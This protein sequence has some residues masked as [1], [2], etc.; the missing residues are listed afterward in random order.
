MQF[1]L[2][3]GLRSKASPGLAGVCQTC[4]SP[5]IAKCGSRRAWHWAHRGL[6]QCDP[7]WEESDWHVGWKGK[8]PPECQEILQYAESG[9]KHI[10][11]V[12]M[13]DGRVIEFQHSP[14]KNEERDARE[15]FYKAMIWVV[16]G[17]ARKRDLPGFKKTL[18]QVSENPLVYSGQARDCALLRDWFGRPVDV[19]F[20]FGEPNLWHLH[21][22]PEGVVIFTSVPVTLFI[23][24][25][26]KGMSFR[27]IRFMSSN[28]PAPTPYQP[29][30]LAVGFPRYLPR[31]QRRGHRF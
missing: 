4:T 12:K 21:P 5:V 27:R 7:W 15:L 11:D 8:F 10:A 25:L 30:R 28:A 6:R 29:P 3:D 2:I 19:F 31:L 24:T 13:P 18:R 9:E 14:L 1:A 17:L 23:E 20:D 22:S 26:Q 16:D